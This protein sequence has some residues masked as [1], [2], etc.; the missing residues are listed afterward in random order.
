MA[1]RLLLYIARVLEKTINGI[2]KQFLENYGSEVFTML[3]TDWNLEDA[4][5]VWYEDG[6]EEGLEV[7]RKEKLE[8]AR[9]ALA[10]GLTA[11]LVH[12]ITGLDIETIKSLVT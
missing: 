8:I 5:K 4:K 10:K 9:N 11:E 12:E 2:M 6:R 3:L 1:L 7:G